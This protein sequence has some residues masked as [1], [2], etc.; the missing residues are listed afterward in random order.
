MSYIEPLEP[1]V[2]KIE[3]CARCG[4]DHESICFQPFSKPLEELPGWRYWAMCPVQ[5][6]PILMCV[7]EDTNASSS[8]V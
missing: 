4:E 8:R 6:E 7:E 5:Q 2:T 1:I 3:R